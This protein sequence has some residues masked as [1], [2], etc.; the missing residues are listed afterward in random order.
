MPF[1]QDTDRSPQLFSNSALSD[2]IDGQLKRIA[3]NISKLDA[4]TL[5]ARSTDD[6]V[7]SIVADYSLDV[8]QLSPNVTQSVPVEIQRDLQDYGRNATVSGFVY[9]FTVPFTG[10]RS[11]LLRWPNAQSSIPPR[12]THDDTGIVIELSGFNLTKSELEHELEKRINAI[13]Q[14]LIWQSGMAVAYNGQIG[15]LARRLADERKEK[16]LEAR[17]IAASLGYPMQRSPNVPLTHVATNVRR[18]LVPTTPPVQKP[19]VPEP[20]LEE[21]EYQHILKIIDDMTLIMERSPSAFERMKEEHLRDFYLVVLNGHY[22]GQATGETFNTSGKTDILIRVKNQNIFIAE[23]KF[24]R[25][26]KEFQEAIDQILSYLNWRDTKACLIVF[27]RNKNFSEMLATMQK[28]AANH[29]H[30]KKGP[31]AQG[32][33]RFRFIFENP[34]DTYKQIVLTVMAF[35]IPTP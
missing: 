24:W 21:A 28:A 5:L 25:G 4:D 8:P 7:V 17:D 1:F 19:Y 11:L 29:K 33:S 13:K 2:V 31:D 34:S 20:V 35:D 30:C 22:E 15:P 32:E 12:A 23:C 6:I 9:R 26:E 10:D 3:E 27:N 16:I 14:Y 18:R